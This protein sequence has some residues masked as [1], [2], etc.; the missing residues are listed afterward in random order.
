MRA[1]RPNLK[2]RPTNITLSRKT[3]AMLAAFADFKESHGE[4]SPTRT[5]MVEQGLALFLEKMANRFPEFRPT[6]K[7]IEIQFR[8]ME[9]FTQTSKGRGVVRSLAARGRRKGP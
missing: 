6:L 3:L 7:D 2:R 1:L 8:K 4:M 9:E 5:W